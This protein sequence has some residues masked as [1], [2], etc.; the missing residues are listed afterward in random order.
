M[1]YDTKEEAISY[2]KSQCTPN[3]VYWIEEVDGKWR[4]WFNVYD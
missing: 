2:A 3:M 4:V 1:L